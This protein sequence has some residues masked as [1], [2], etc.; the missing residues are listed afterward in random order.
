MPSKYNPKVIYNKT[1]EGIKEL[2]YRDPQSPILDSSE[3]VYLNSPDEKLTK[4]LEFNEPVVDVRE[5]TTDQ[6]FNPFLIIY[7]YLISLFPIVTWIYRYNL[8]WLYG[9]LIAGITVGIVA[10]P[11]AMS[12]AK[13]ATLSPEYGLYSTFVGVFI[14]CF[15][16]TS[17]DVCIGPVA[18]MSLQVGRT[19]TKVTDKYPEYADKGPVIATTLALICGGAAAGIGLL[20]LGFILEFIPIPAVMG[21]MTGSAFSIMIGQVPSLFGNSKFLNTRDSTYLVFINFWKQIKHTKTDVAFGIPPLVALFTIKFLCDYLTKRAPKYK[22]IWFYLSVL[23]NGIIIVLF[24]A[25]AYGCYKDRRSNA[26]ISLIKTVPSGLKHTGVPEIDHNIVTALASEIPVSVIVLLLEHISIAKSFGRVNNY[27]VSPDQE[28][29]AIGVTNL[30]G[31]FFN[32]YPATGSFSRTALKAKCGVRTPIAGIFT[33]AVVLLA[34]YCLTDAFYWIPNATLSA[35]IIHAVYDLMASPKTSWHFWTVS[36]IESIIFIAAVFIT[37]FSTIEAGIYFSICASC[38]LMLL[39]IAFARGQFLGRVEYHELIDPT[40]ISRNGQ[41]VFDGRLSKVSSNT[42]SNEPKKSVAYDEEQ[43]TPA[44]TADNQV[45][46][47]EIRPASDPNT[48][49]SPVIP[50]SSYLRRFRW[51]PL[52]LKNLNPNVKVI[53]PPPG[54]VVF[55]PNE[56]FIYPNASRQVDFI[57]DEVKRSTRPAIIDIHQKIGDRPWNDDGPRHRKIDPDF[58]DPRPVLRAVVFDMTSVPHI[59]A[60]GVQNIIDIRAAILNYTKTESVEYHFVGLISQWSRRALIANKLGVGHISPSHHRVDAAERN[61]GPKWS[62]APVADFGYPIEEIQKTA[63]A[64]FDD[65][66]AKI[67]GY[68][69]EDSPGGEPSNHILLPLVGTNTPYFHFSMSDLDYLFEEEVPEQPEIVV[70]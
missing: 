5:Y 48:N 30:I 58:V 67:G 20:R 65:E 24:T 28:L 61:F 8:T 34:I 7:H 9:D 35:V 45:F 2:N 70:V 49:V 37:V 17:K 40:I 11:Q 29:I 36:P 50:Q 68:S 10:V 32:A 63:S 62:D 21:F 22:I 59:D 42:S 19:I 33:G 53:P 69:G 23:R 31:V 38:A 55:R 18:V 16:A 43:V 41:I 26:P 60:T 12:Y 3:G 14:Y 66:E 39:R 52:N 1:V 4:V 46:E 54:V 6:R 64:K 15:F 57:L 25:I 47:T 51:V 13:I 44:K 27:R 56:S